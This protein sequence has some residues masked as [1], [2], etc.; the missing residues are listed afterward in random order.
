MV[1]ARTNLQVTAFVSQVA[2]PWAE[3]QSSKRLFSSSLCSNSAMHLS[4]GATE[5][6]QHLSGISARNSS[7]NNILRTAP[8]PTKDHSLWQAQAVSSLDFD[9]PSCMLTVQLAGLLDEG[10]VDFG[11][12]QLLI[13]RLQYSGFEYGTDR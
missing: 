9:R 7:N 12:P 2:G 5:G 8:R 4:R 1:N 3:F 6:H 10:F 11:N 13:C